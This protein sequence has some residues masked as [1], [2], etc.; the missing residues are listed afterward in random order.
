LDLEAKSQH[1]G[2]ANTEARLQAFFA[3]HYN[4]VTNTFNNRFHLDLFIEA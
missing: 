4:L 3:K 2:L 1:I